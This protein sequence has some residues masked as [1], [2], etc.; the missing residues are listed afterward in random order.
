[1]TIRVVIADDQALI[2]TGLR[3]IVSTAADLGVVGEAATGLQAVEEVLRL[4][5]DVVLM[6]IRMP[7]LDGIAATRRLTAAGCPT[8]VLV[9]RPRSTSTTTSTGRYGPAPAASCSRTRRR[10]TCTPPSGSSPP[11]TRCSHRR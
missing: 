1:M 3:G 4:R 6:D 2:R 11:A 8:R 5:P 7:D 10:P 9:L